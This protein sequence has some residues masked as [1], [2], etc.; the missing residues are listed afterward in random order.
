MEMD[1]VMLVP[2]QT[3]MDKVT[4]KVMEE[5]IMEKMKNKLMKKLIGMIL[6]YWQN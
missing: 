5:M 2:V 4:D 1:K 3:K 6:H